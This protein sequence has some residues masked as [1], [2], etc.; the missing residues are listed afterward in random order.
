[1]F[2]DASNN[3]VSKKRRLELKR[4]HLKQFEK[5]V[6]FQKYPEFNDFISADKT[7]GL[8]PFLPFDITDES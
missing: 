5:L 8:L 4:L 3:T 2:I 7:Y 1:M 6:E